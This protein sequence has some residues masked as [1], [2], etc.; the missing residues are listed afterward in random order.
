MARYWRRSMPAAACDGAKTKPKPK[1]TA[2]SSLLTA[3]LAG[4]PR[5]NMMT[6]KTS[7]LPGILT[8]WRSY[9]VPPSG[10][11]GRKGP[12][13]AGTPCETEIQQG[14]RYGVPPSGG[15]TRANKMIMKIINVVD[16]ADGSPAEAGTP[17]PELARPRT[18]QPY[19]QK[20]VPKTTVRP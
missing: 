15:R 18:V 6:I 2:S 14:V 10:G 20:R 13:K 9:G 4:Q 1:K 5:S 19:G 16:Q 7:N 3:W 11:S 17:N 12:A 8:R